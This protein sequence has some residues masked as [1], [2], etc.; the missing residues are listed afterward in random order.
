MTRYGSAHTLET[1]RKLLLGLALAV[2]LALPSSAAANHSWNGWH[3]A[4][5][6]SS[7]TLVIS[8]GVSGDWDTVF[9]GVRSDWNASLTGTGVS[10]A[11]GSSGVNITTQSKSWGNNGWLGLAQVW[12]KGGH[13][14][15]ASVKLNDYYDWYYPAATR[16]Q[17]KQQVFCQEVGHTL[18]LD[19]QDEPNTCMNDSNDL[20]TTPY[21]HPN[22]HDG[23]E[24][25]SLYDHVDSSGRRAAHERGPFTIHV[26][27]AHL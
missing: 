20:R 13:I 25:R 21:P 2:T 16:L 5:T 23:A 8:D 4:K 9:P 12:I 7:R 18:G 3:W 11:L 24:L 15:R 14:T 26:V 19:H 6:S 22:A 10:L 17:G 27:P 1:V